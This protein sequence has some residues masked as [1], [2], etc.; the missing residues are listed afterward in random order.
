MA[1]TATKET[2]TVTQQPTETAQTDP[3]V[4]RLWKEFYT[5]ITRRDNARF[6]SKAYDV[7][8]KRSE[9]VWSVVERLNLVDEFLAYDSTVTR[10]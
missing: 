8:E 9:R 10:Y 4:R 1:P 2:N 5:A 7:A 6:G 3:R